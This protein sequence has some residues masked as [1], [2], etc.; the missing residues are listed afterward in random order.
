MIATLGNGN[1][2]L[3]KGI[4]IY[5][6][7]TLGF[8]T[9]FY[10]A[11]RN[12]IGKIFEFF[13]I[14]LP[15]VNLDIIFDV[16][17]SIQDDVVGIM[18]KG[19]FMKILTKLICLYR[20][21]DQSL[22]CSGGTNLFTVIRDGIEF[23]VKEAKKFFEKIGNEIRFALDQA[24]KWISSNILKPAENFFKGEC[25]C[26]PQDEKQGLLCY[27][28]CKAGYSGMLTQC[29]Q[30]CPANYRNDGYW[31]FKPSPYGRDTFAIWDMEPCK[32][33]YPSL[34]CEQ[35]GLFIYDK[36]KPNFHNVACC[37]CSPDCP[38]GM[39]DIGISCQKG[40]Y[41]RGAGTPLVCTEDGLK[42]I[43]E[44]EKKYKGGKSYKKKKLRLK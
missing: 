34:G 40:A 18:L 26:H 29:V 17:L 32:R 28:R 5:L 41:G 38:A 35:W 10:N 21:S 25:K 12:T 43:T 3:G 16:V 20:Y 9:E 19:T 6:K 39:T 31:C 37:I 7:T 33:K 24:G 13:K 44:E 4:Y 1:M 22:S 36:C 15:E 14:P 42:Q 30:D 27:P 2:G 23:V 8:L 11:F